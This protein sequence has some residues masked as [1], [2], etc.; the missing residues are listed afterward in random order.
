MFELIQAAPDMTQALIAAAP[1]TVGASISAI[2]FTDWA[3]SQI[4]DF[5]SMLKTLCY[6]IAIII[7]LVATFAGKFGIAKMVIGALTAGL[8]VYIAM[9][10]D[11]GD[12]PSELID[13]QV[14]QNAAPA[15][16]TPYTPPH[17]SLMTGGPINVGR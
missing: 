7:F 8:F 17:D 15:L 10:L 3:D 1:K 9:N 14:D 5:K 11:K 13:D 16:V 12:K 2:S 6:L 4:T